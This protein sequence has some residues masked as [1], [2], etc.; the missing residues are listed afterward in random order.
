MSVSIYLS[1]YLSISIYVY[2]YVSVYISIYT[3][4]RECESEL[5]GGQP[6]REGRAP[7]RERARDVVELDG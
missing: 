1:I 5:R 4:V 2:T 7:R 6:R 3:V